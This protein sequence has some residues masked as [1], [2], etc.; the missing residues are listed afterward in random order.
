MSLVTTNLIVLRK[1][2]YMETSLIISGLSP[3]FGKLDLLAKGELKI[4]SKKFELKTV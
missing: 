3:D 4:S 2:P 1:T